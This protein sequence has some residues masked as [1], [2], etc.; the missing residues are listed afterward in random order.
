MIYQI[1]CDLI[2]DSSIDIID[3]ILIK[4]A[5]I[6]LDTYDVCI[7][8]HIYNF[9]IKWLK[10]AQYE[11]IVESETIQQWDG[12]LRLLYRAMQSKRDDSESHIPIAGI[13]VQTAARQKLA[14]V[15]AHEHV[16]WMQKLSDV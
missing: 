3:C 10:C 2:V 14:Q 15:I 12:G 16:P 7:V 6:P 4:F 11:N 5:S 9:C 13:N 1:S 8:D